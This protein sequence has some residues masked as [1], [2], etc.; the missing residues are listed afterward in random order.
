MRRRMG[1]ISSSSTRRCLA[2]VVIAAVFVVANPV[3]T[4]IRYAS[5]QNVVPVF[6]GW[7]RNPD[8]S[9]MMVFGYMNRNYEQEIDVPVG[10]DNKIEPGTPDQGQPTHFYTRRQQF[11]FKV[12]VPADWGKKDLIWTLNVA[13]KPEKAYASLLPFWELGPFV[14]QENRGS[15]ANIGDAPEP[16]DPPN[17]AL[18]GPSEL[19]IETGDTVMLDLNVSDDG[20]PVPRR[21]P[22]S[23]AQ[24]R[25]DSDGAVITPTGTPGPGGPAG[26]GTGVRRE[27]PLTQAMVRLDPGVALGVTWIVYRGSSVG[28]T[29]QPQRAAV[30]NGKAST[31]L[32]ITQPGTYTLRAY[33]DDGIFVTPVDLTVTARAPSR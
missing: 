31:K 8:G 13:G 4:Q 20:R 11:V 26:V 32:T 1:P 33:A 12:R 22:S 23:G 16:N 28:V 14:Y 2:A 24:V 9:F 27:N 10:P 17:V 18:S 3:S 7:E 25:R 15:T 19:I 30:A 21:R 5:G 6:E 29:F